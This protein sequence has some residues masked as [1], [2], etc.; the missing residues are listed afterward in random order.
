MGS[1]GQPAESD[2]DSGTDTDASSD[3]EAS[4][5][6]CS[7]MPTYLTEEQRAQ[8]L[9]LGD[10]KH[11]RRWRRSMKK[12]VRKVRRMRRRMHGRGTLAFLASLTG[13][14]HEEMFLGTGRNRRHTSGKGKGR[15]GNPKDA[16][17]KTMECGICH[18]TQHFRRECPQ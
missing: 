15:R 12:P 3:D 10:Q 17:G 9:L 8:W 7:D 6:D 13:P 1:A 5:L 2:F 16:N 4:A 11:K 14:Q 18:S